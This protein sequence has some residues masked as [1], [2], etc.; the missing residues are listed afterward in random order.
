MP[1]RLRNLYPPAKVRKLLET[2]KFSARKL[3]IE[4]PPALARLEYHCPYQDTTIRVR[5]PC[6]RASPLIIYTIVKTP[7]GEP[8]ESTSAQPD[9]SSQERVCSGSPGSG[10]GP[11]SV[12][13]AEMLAGFKEN[14]YLCPREPDSPTK[15]PGMSN[16][17]QRGSCARWH[18]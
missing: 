13:S 8:T 9:H 3:Q 1:I 4:N 6:K 18:T 11:R 15:R 10:A 17:T 5:Y 14:A 7:L 16:G 2:A 12:K